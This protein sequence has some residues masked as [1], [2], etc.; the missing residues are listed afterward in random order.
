MWETNLRNPDFSKYAKLCGAMGIRVT[1]RE[2]L[3][4]AMKK[5]FA[6]NGPAMV[7]IITDPLLT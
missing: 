5:A 6:H 4:D 3:D 7:E 1:K 2:E